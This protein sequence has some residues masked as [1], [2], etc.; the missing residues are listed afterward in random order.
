MAAFL[1]V[2][3]S[4]S[5]AS[6]ESSLE[7][8]SSVTCSTSV[9]GAVVIA[10]WETSF[11]FISIYFLS[12]SSSSIY[13]VNV[14]FASRER[15]LRV[16]ASSDNRCLYNPVTRYESFSFHPA[17]NRSAKAFSCGVIL[18]FLHSVINPLDNVGV[19]VSILHKNKYALTSRMP[20]SLIFLYW[21]ESYHII[22][23][24]AIVRAATHRYEAYRI[25]MVF[26]VEVHPGT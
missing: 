22:T 3:S 13:S 17:F 20:L 18:S 12:F 5:C 1:A 16:L 24:G 7:I 4:F 2:M 8:S 26:A 6:L 9:V 25:R 23:V 15:I 21:V 11:S 14:S 19:A 10:V